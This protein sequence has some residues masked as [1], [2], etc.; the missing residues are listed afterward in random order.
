[1]ESPSPKKIKIEKSKKIKLKKRVNF[2]VNKKYYFHVK[3]FCSNFEHS[4]KPQKL[5]LH[6]LFAAPPIE[7]FMPKFCGFSPKIKKNLLFFL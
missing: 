1:V 4:E 2:F 7:Y 5:E 6:H 3:T